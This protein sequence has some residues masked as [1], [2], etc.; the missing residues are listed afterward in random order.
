MKMKKLTA[1]LL[2]AAMTVSLAACGNPEVAQEAP[3][4]EAPAAEA[5]TEGEAPAAEASAAD[6]KSTRLNSSH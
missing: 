2:A 5:E 1:L 3:A 4:A 6:R